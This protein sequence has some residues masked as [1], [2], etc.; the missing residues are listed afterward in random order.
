MK[1]KICRLKNIHYLCPMAIVYQHI[2]KDTKQPFYIGIGKTIARAKSKHSRN[3]YWKNIVE[4]YGYD[5]EILH[6][7][8]TW[9][10]CCDIEKK[11]IKQYGRV[12]I[13]TGILSNMTDGGDGNNNYSPEVIEKIA[14]KKRG[15]S[16][17]KE[18]RQKISNNNGKKGKP[19]LWGKHTKE[20]IE[21]IR[22]HSTG[23]NHTNDSI[24]KQRKLK[25]GKPI[26]IFND[27]VEL[28]FESISSCIKDFFNISQYNNKKDFDRVRGNIRD[29]LN[30]NRSQKTY[31]GFR[32][33]YD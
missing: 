22:E 32:F 10:K 33:R 11:Y 16:L 20:T 7:D 2:R 12:D 23:R 8:L 4:K 15:I 26:I 27:D 19:N 29:I 21:I 25:N 24:K 18:H 17:T 5:I 13:G 14:S 30:P 9:E 31:K 28:R 1:K 6:I 3:D